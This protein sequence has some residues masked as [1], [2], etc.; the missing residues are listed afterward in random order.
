[1]DS[2]DLLMFEGPRLKLERA[3]YHVQSLSEWDANFFIHEKN[4]FTEDI[5]NP[6]G[7]TKNRIVRIK[8]QIPPNI[9][10]VIGDAVHNLR[11]TLDLLACDLVRL[12]NKS[13]K[14][15]YFPFCWDASKLEEMIQRRNIHRAAP[16]VVDLIRSLKPYKDGNPLLRGIHDL[17]IADKHHAL[18]PFA[19]AALQATQSLN[20]AKGWYVQRR[21]EDV[22]IRNVRD[23]TVLET[24]VPIGFIASEHDPIFQLTFAPIDP[25]PSEPVSETLTNLSKLIASIIQT[26]ETHLQRGD[27]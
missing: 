15:V 13:D 19:G 22:H 9:S 5:P 1:M 6:D 14:D 17:D 20:F 11:T 3:N 4:Y 8:N 12:N 18:I 7:R 24:N 23:G 25:F 16:D 27:Q 21:V 10:C 26:F 2:G